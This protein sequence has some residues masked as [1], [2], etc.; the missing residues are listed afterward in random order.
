LLEEIISRRSIRKYIDKKP[1]EDAKI[2]ELIESARIAPSGSNTQPW[3]FIVV[4]S[5]I[6]RQRLAEI[7]HNQKWMMSA[8]V[9]IVCVADIRSRIK[10]EVE[11]SLNENS[12]EHELKQIIRD[13]SIA[14]EHMVLSAEGLGLST[15]WV[16]WFTQEEIRPILNIPSDKYV[17]GIITLGYSDESPKARPRKNLEDIMHYE[18][19]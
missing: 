9:F 19:W 10:E 2:I 11:L 4:K 12:P 1:V 14:I 15:C 5:D 18:N 13:T 3:H 16:A 17:V 6:T 7:S 8:P